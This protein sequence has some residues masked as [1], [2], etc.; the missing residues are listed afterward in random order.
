MLEAEITNLNVRK[1]DLEW[2]QQIQRFAGVH[3]W[4]KCKQ[5]STARAQ[6][7]GK[8]HQN[9]KLWEQVGVSPWQFGVL[10]KEFKLCLVGNKDLLEHDKQACNISKYVFYKNRPARYETDQ[11]EP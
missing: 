11:R 2:E 8:E 1:Q 10:V 5:F 9:T 4:G 7:S 3:I 6:T